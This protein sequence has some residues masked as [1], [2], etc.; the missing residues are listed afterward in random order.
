MKTESVSICAECNGEFDLEDG[1]FVWHGVAF[2]ELC[3]P[4][5]EKEN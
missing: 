5:E 2:C 1:G 3:D 4:E